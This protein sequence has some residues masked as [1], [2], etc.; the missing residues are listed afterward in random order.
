[1][2][3]SFLYFLNFLLLIVETSVF[4]ICANGF[5][6]RRRPALYHYISFFILVIV[7]FINAGVFETNLPLRL[8]SISLIVALWIYL[9]YTSTFIKSLFVSILAFSLCSVLDVVFATLP[10]LIFGEAGNLIYTD[11]AAYYVLCFAAKLFEVL[12]A[13][14]L[15]TWARQRLSSQ[16]VS[17]SEWVRV[18][19]FPLC[20]MVIALYLSTILFQEPQ[21]SEKMLYCTLLLLVANFFSIAFINYLD[22]KNRENLQN[23]V[24]LQNLKLE[25]EH[26]T[27]LKEAYDVQRRHTHDFNNHLAV[28]RSLADR[29]ASA[30]EFTAYLDSVLAAEPPSPIHVNTKRHVADI[31]L[32]QKL[33]LAKKKDITFQCALDDLSD[34]SL[35]DDAL[36]VVLTNLIDNAM[37]A[38]EKIPEPRQRHIL[39]KMQIQAEYSHLYIENTCAA[40]VRIRGNHIATTKNN[41]MVHGYGLK[42][43]YA[44]LDRQ[45]AIYAVEYLPDENKFCFSAMIPHTGE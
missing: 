3:M 19:F 9:N 40:A 20:I 21:L 15:R 42:N 12:I 7:A 1:M 45:H 44:M 24:L 34:F 33:S 18:L 16:A 4:M 22:R 2:N 23:A 5:F 35:T 37:E 31:V 43:V 32:S 29:G 28:L 14:L 25:T 8:I 27:A 10:G 26:V 11:P 38:C 30:E 36:V 6:D 39:L 17:R 41:P 13:I